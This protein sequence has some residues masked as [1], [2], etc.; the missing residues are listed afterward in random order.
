MFDQTQTR[1]EL[2]VLVGDWAQDLLGCM[3]SEYIGV[4]FLLFAAAVSGAGRLHG[5]D[6][7]DNDDM[8]PIRDKMDS[9]RIREI[10][11]GHF[12]ADTD[13]LRAL[14][15]PLPPGTHPDLRRYTFNPLFSKPIVSD[16]MDDY[17]VPVPSLVFRKASPAGLYYTGVEHRDDTGRWGSRFSQ[18][19]GYLV[20]AYVG[21][22]LELLTDTALSPAIKYGRRQGEESVDWIVVFDDLVLL[23]EVKSRRPTEAVRLGIDQAAQDFQV[24][25]RHAVEQLNT[26]VFV[27]HPTANDL[28]F[29]KT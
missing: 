14:H 8:A 5:L 2:Q 15:R 4:A 18:D 10:A 27:A 20:E 22:Q 29:L 13:V 9:E 23:V 26:T 28:H 21:R 3:L 7:L 16:L 11:D 6:W 17:L 25:I 1:N 12:F 19:V 24:G